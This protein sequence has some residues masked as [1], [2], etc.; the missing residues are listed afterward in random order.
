MALTTHNSKRNMAETVCV[1]IAISHF[2]FELLKPEKPCKS[3]SASHI[4]TCKMPPQYLKILL[5]VKLQYTTKIW[6]QTWSLV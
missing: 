4:L 5:L 6:Q 2:K 1:Q 3:Q